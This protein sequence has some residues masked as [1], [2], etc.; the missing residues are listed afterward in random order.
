MTGR[1]VRIGIT[2]DITIDIAGIRAVFIRM[3]DTDIV[4]AL[5][6]ARARTRTG[7][8]T[9]QGTIASE[10]SIRWLCEPE[11]DCDTKTRFSM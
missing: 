3:Q 6:R 10:R 2:V 9:I 8:V 5:T 7:T 1:G 11:I 4:L